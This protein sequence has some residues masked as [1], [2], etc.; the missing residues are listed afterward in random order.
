MIVN[1]N[2]IYTQNYLAS[3]GL[4]LVT[5][6]FTTYLGQKFIKWIRLRELRWLELRPLT[7]GFDRLLLTRLIVRVVCGP[8]P[9]YTVLSASLGR[10]ERQIP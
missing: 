6:L 1:T 4:R 7:S 3:L 9:R 10:L 2:F 8:Q 5:F